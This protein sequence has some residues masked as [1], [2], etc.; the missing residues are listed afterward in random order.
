LAVPVPERAGAEVV[1]PGEHEASFASEDHVLVPEHT[2][3][4]RAEVGYPRVG[5]GVVLVVARDEED[6][7]FGAEIGE[8]RHVIPELLDAAVDE[9]SRDDHGVRLER[10]DLLD[11]AAHERAIDR[12]PDVHVGELH[13]AV[14]R[15]TEPGEAHPHTLDRVAREHAREA[16]RRQPHARERRGASEHPGH[17]PSPRRVAE[18]R[19]RVAGEVDAEAEHVGREHGEDQ[20]EKEAEPHVD[21]PRQRRDEGPRA[22]REREPE[23]EQHGHPSE[24]RLASA[25]P[26]QRERRVA[27]EAHVEVIVPSAEHRGHDEEEDGDS[28]EGHGGGVSLVARACRLVGALYEATMPPRERRAAPR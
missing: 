15:P 21:E 25:G 7:V 24:P 20:E 12:G 27:D 1:D 14:P 2:H 10:V 11:D 26:P 8:G 9:V 19:R 22:A 6:A 13:D 18:R 3:A 23:H 17:E 5:A 28:A 4:E 16:A